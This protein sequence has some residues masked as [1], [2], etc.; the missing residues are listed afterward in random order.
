MQNSGPT[1]SWIRCSVQRATC[2]HAQQYE[3]TLVFPFA[4]YFAEAV[5]S[6]IYGPPHS[7]F[8]IEKREQ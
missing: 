5:G 2:S 7:Q 4:V 6:R 3:P 1:G 8:L